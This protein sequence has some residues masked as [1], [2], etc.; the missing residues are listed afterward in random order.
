MFYGGAINHHD[1][2]WSADHAEIDLEESGNL[3]KVDHGM[4]LATIRLDGFVSASAFYRQGIIVTHPLCAA[5]A[6]SLSLNARTRPGGFV[7]VELTDTED[8]VLAGFSRAEC[9]VFSGDAVRHTV[10]WRGHA[11]LPEAA[12]AS[13][14]KLRF[15]LKQA[16]LFSHSFAP[17]R[18]H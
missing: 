3:A 17:V 15:Y 6:G 16:D 1:Y 4:G 12:R 8:H 18:Q 13:G 2:W 7:A 5:Q 9:D 10:T 14:V 11:E